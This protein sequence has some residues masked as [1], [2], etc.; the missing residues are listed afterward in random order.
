MCCVFWF[1]EMMDDYTLPMTHVIKMRW[2]RTNLSEIFKLINNTKYNFQWCQFQGTQLKWDMLKSR[3]LSGF[4]LLSQLKNHPDISS[5]NSLRDRNAGA[6]YPQSRHDTKPLFCFYFCNSSF[7]IP[8]ISAPPVA[9]F[10][11]FG[12]LLLICDP[13]WLGLPFEDSWGKHPS[14]LLW[15]LWRKKNERDVGKV[16]VISQS[17]SPTTLKTMRRLKVD[18][19]ERWGQHPFWNVHIGILWPRFL[20]SG[21]R[22]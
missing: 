4:F 7:F 3:K 13:N 20:P 2:S 18:G 6:L 12:W 1:T 5:Y 19:K 9:V 16:N 8:Q 10:L 14:F 21:D 15:H 11:Y 22:Y 17:Y